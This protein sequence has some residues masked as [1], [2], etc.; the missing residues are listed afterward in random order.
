MMK[1]NNNINVNN[2]KGL[3]LMNRCDAAS[4]FIGVAVGLFVFS[5]TY[6]DFFLGSCISFVC[7]VSLTNTYGNIEAQW[8]KD[9]DASFSIS[10]ALIAILTWS[11]LWCMLV[12]LV[13]L[14][15]HWAIASTLIYCAYMVLM[16]RNRIKYITALG[17]YCIFLSANRFT[18][19]SIEWEWLYSLSSN[20]EASVNPSMIC[21]E[22]QPYSVAAYC[23]MVFMVI[24]VTLLHVDRNSMFSQTILSS[25]ISMLL[26]AP[27]LAAFNILNSWSITK[28]YKKNNINI[29]NNHNT[30]KSNDDDN[31]VNNND[32][33]ESQSCSNQ[34]APSMILSSSTN[35]EKRFQQQAS[36]ISQHQRKPI[37]DLHIHETNRP[38][39]RHFAKIHQ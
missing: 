21:H 16:T 7:F 10:S 5:K 17:V 14:G 20:I 19:H 27:Y 26:P 3:S 4:C 1:I 12:G 33:A 13:S 39:T 18:V 31:N 22:L 9:S 35:I 32:D 30:N 37:V 28:L 29:S 6:A 15:G 24:L 8:K 23:A 2:N 36:L 34:Q 38:L 11:L 25:P